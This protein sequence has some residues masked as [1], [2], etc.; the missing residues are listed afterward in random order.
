LCAKLKCDKCNH[1]DEERALKGTWCTI[2]LNEAVLNGYQV[3][4]IYEVWHFNKTT[5]YDK[6]TNTGGLFASYVNEF[7]KIKEEASG[8]PAHVMT[9]TEIDNYIK[10][11]YDAEGITL[12]VEKIKKNKG[13]HAVVKA[14]L[15]ALWGRLGMKTNRNKIKLI[16]E[17]SEWFKFCP[18]NQYIIHYVNYC[19]NN[20]QIQVFYNEAEQLHNPSSK[21]N[22]VIAAFVTAHAR[23]KLHREMMKLGDRLL[24]TDTDSIIFISRKN[25]YE[26]PLGDNLGDFTDETEGDPIVE[27]VSAGPKNRAHVTLSGAKSCIVKGFT[28]NYIASLAV[29]FESM[30]EIVLNDNS[31][32]ISVNQM[33]IIRDI[34]NWRLYSTEAIKEYGFTYD[35]RILLT[36]LTTIPYGYL[37]D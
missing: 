32:K 20:N 6:T 21:N 28:L 2:E 30:K 11:F 10:S 13:L 34:K 1:S 29:N 27:F 19:N 37:I 31:K 23:I 12:D 9:E 36:D 18:N 3:L 7:L 15:N 5:K 26:P 14:L 25:I 4:K 35:K 22:V 24:Y 16:T 33:K 8:M 17:Q